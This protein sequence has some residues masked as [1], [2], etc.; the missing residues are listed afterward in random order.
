LTAPT[1]LA[2]AFSMKKGETAKEPFP[3][4]AGYAF[5]AVDDIQA[6]R[7]PDLAEVKDRVR[8]DVAR[9]KAMDLAKQMAAQLRARAE[10]DGLEKAATAM[11]LVRKE[12]SGEVGRGEAFGD[13]GSAAS[14]EAAFALEPSTLSEPLRLDSG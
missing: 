11:G 4:G 12:T 9:E 7:V 14:L 3:A 8:A 13:L 5:I 1:L 2:R 6:P 10:T